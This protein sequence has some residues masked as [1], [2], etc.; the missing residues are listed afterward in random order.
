[1]LRRALPLALAL[2]ACGSKAGPGE[3]P[4]APVPPDSSGY[5]RPLPEVK[6]PILVWP[7]QLASDLS[8]W[9][10]EFVAKRFVGSQKLP[11]K[12]SDRIRAHNPG[13]LV[14]QYRLATGLSTAHNLVREDTWGP[15]ATEA[16]IESFSLRGSTGRVAHPDQYFLADVRN[17][18]WQDQHI[19]E[20]LQRMPLNDFDGI[21]LDTAHLRIDGFRPNDWHISF[22]DPDVTK[23]AGCWDAPARRFFERLVE[24]LRA[25]T[26]KYRAVGNFGPMVTSWD[27]ND[28]LAPLDGGMV[29]QFMWMRGPLNEADWHISASRLLKLLG[30]ERIFIAEPQGYPADDPATRRWLLGNYLLF[31]GRRTYA[32]FYPAGTDSVGPPVWLPEYEVDLGL[33]E[34]PLETTLAPLCTGSSEAR[35][36]SG[37][38]RRAYARGLVFVNP[39]SSARNTTLPPPPAGTDW[40]TLDFVGGGYVGRDGEPAP[41]RVLEKIVPPGDFSLAASSALIFRAVAR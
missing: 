18:A 16:A 20:I 27:P 7:D 28:Y 26:P 22:C 29:E 12:L 5:K 32:A 24:R 13:F 10:V 35:R 34:K 6:G 39:G 37:V 14:L 33:P 3:A 40:V 17:P 4:P 23:L 15:D 30:N 31:Q 19:A 21:F 41:G 9:Q 38:Y 25:G 8:P 2:L 36:C 1:M 11:R